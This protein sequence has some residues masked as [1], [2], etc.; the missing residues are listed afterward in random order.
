MDARMFQ[1]VRAI[2]EVCFDLVR[3]AAL[4]LRSGSVIRADNLVLCKQL[5]AYIERGIKP[6]YAGRECAK[7]ALGP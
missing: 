4:F 1:T 2:V 6:L 7:P 5:A 3:L